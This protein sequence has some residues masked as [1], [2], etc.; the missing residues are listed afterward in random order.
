MVVEVSP[1]QMATSVGRC[2]RSA[3]SICSGWKTVPQGASITRTSP[4]Q[5]SAISTFRFP[6]R[7]N[8]GT[9][10]LS[11]GS[12]TE[13]RTASIPARAVPSTTKVH[14]FCVWKSARYSAMVWTM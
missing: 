2:R 4:P 14:S 10:T 1:W 12:M 6:K 9:R 8:T 13:T 11:P 5:R 3:V 7:P